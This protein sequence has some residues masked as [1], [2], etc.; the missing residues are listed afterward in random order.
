MVKE[1]AN[2]AYDT[3]K[4]ALLT[5]DILTRDA[6]IVARNANAVTR[7]PTEQKLHNTSSFLPQ[8]LHN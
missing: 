7:A 3:I 6:E 1:Y 8:L 2:S 4:I 5:A